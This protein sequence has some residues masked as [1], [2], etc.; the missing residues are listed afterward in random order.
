MVAT[1][2]AALALGAIA[3]VV[4]MSS[5]DQRDSAGTIG[6]AVATLTCAL[7]MVLAGVLRRRSGFLAFVVVVLLVGTLASAAAPR[8]GAVVVGSIDGQVRTGTYVQPVGNTFLHV[9]GDA[10]GTAPARME[11][12]Q[13]AGSIVV[14][15][16]NDARLDL[17]VECGSCWVEFA[18]VDGSSTAYFDGAQLTAPGNSEWAGSIGT[19]TTPGRPDATLSIRTGASRIL[20]VNHEDEEARK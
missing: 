9:D 17:R 5:P 6:L 14:E 16:R 10:V 7:A 19:G 20:I 1:I 15:L 3:S 13:G 8:P 12:L 2:G 4:A 18:R 11:L